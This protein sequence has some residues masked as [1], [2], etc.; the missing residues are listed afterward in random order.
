MAQ[1]KKQLKIKPAVE[2]KIINNNL[3]YPL[4]RVRF[5]MIVTISGLLIFLVGARPDVIGADR[6]LVIGYIQIAVMLLGLAI[7]G[8]GGYAT[9]ISL[10]YKHTPSIATEI[11]MRL[12]S[13][14]YVIAFISGMAD[15][16]GL[17]SHPYALVV[18]YFGI[19]QARGVQ[20]GQGFI[21][22]GLLMMFPYS[23]SP[24]FS[25]HHELPAQ[26]HFPN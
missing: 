25:G 16:I 11:G 4:D 14:G 5:G 7:L 3:P 8:I 20:I 1:R 13:T 18:P 24:L 26:P 22:I 15:F 6:S 17:G 21:A 19:W 23:R 2:P 12:I 10:W 9:L